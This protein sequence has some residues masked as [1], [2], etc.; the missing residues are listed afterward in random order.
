MIS[1]DRLQSVTRSPHLPLALLLL[2][3]STV[4]L[5]GG[6][7]GSFYRPHRHSWT[8]SQHLTIAVNISP[9]HGFQRFVR[10]IMDEDGAVRYAPYNRF[11]IGGY[12]SMKLATLPASGDLSAQILFARILML[13]FFAAAAVLAYLSLCRLVSNRW[14]ALTATLLSFSSFYLLYYND[15][16]ANEGMPDLFGVMLAFHGMVVFVQEGRFRQLLVKTCIGL[17]LG[18]HVFALLLPFVILGLASD[19]LRARS[20]AASLQSSTVFHRGK[21]MAI[22]LLRSRYLL[23]GIVALG[24]GLAIL[25]FNF[26]MEYIALDGQTPLTELP[27]FQSMLNRTSVNQGA[28]RASWPWGAFFEVQFLRIFLMFVPYGLIGSGG[29]LESPPWQ[30]QFQGVLI[31]AANINAITVIEWLSKFQGVVLGVGLSGACLIGLMFTRQRMLFATLASFGF[32]WALPMRQTTVLHGFESMYYVGLP[33]VF[34]SLVLLRLRGL[35]RGRL[36]PY[37]AAGSALLFAVSSFQMSRVAHG[38]ESARFAQEAEQDMIVIRELTEET[39]G[40]TVLPLDGLSPTES[41]FGWESYKMVYYLN[42]SFLRFEDRSEQGFSLMRER[43]DTDALLTPQNRQFFLYDS[44]GLMTAYRSM[45]RSISSGKPLERSN[46]DVYLKENRLY[47]LKEPCPPI[48]T[49]APF[50][51]HVVPIDLYD[52]PDD[53]RGHGFDNLDFGFGHRGVMFDGKCL[54][55]VRLPHYDAA[56]VRTGQFDGDGEVWSVE[57]VDEDP[58]LMAEY[59]SIVSGELAASAEFDLYIDGRALYYVKEPCGV[60]DTQPPF[61]LHVVPADLGDLP[62]DRRGHGFDNLDFG[63]DVRGVMFDDRCVARVFLPKH[64]VARI[65]TGQ[66]DGAERIWEV[67]LAPDALE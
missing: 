31:P 45:Y 12:L 1:L 33:M 27:S 20:A 6:D 44:A 35:A 63:F 55:I 10:R 49:Q 16:T 40:V 28:V 42:R 19:L 30:T 34:F 58:S 66:Y 5:F 7:R 2:A 4:F 52:L 62:D 25:T 53:R 11:P 56:N 38:A 67:E 24:F 17:L 22:A 21:R 14:I 41:G 29:I 36:I 61:F 46:F 47:Y 54:A 18:W 8:S 51:L 43:I 48:D 57:Y 3:L 26:A 9:E 15:M 37:L 50:F 32:F 59:Q 23:L 60:E 39:G 65:T 64:D 13:L